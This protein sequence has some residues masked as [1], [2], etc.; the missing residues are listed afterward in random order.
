SVNLLS[1]GDILVDHAEAV[2]NFTAIA[3]LAFT[4]SL[5]SIIT[6]GDI[7]IDAGGPVALGNSSAGGLIDVNGSQIDFAS[8]VAGT[9]IELSTVPP[10]LTAGGTG[11]ITGGSIE[12]GAG[13]SSLV[14]TAGDIALSGDASADGDLF[15]IAN[16]GS[17]ALGGQASVGGLLSLSAGT[18]IAAGDLASATGDV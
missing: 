5:N 10:R 3:G 2:T 15:L 14:T 16:G 11:D 1:A 9:T 12:A 18:T 13:V 6:G 8:L 7:V 17:I 4:T